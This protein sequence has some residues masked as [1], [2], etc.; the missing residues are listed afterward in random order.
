VGKPR[1]PIEAD[2]E[3]WLRALFPDAF[4]LPLASFHHEFWAWVWALEKGVKPPPFVA[5]WPR[6]FG[7]STNAEAAVA[8]VALMGKRSYGLY[9]SGTQD[10]A[11]DHVQNVARMLERPEVE[12]YYG[13]AAR[14]AVTKYGQREGWR[15]NRLRT[16]G[17]FT[18]DAAGLQSGL[19]GAK[20]DDARPDFIILDD[21]DSKHDSPATVAK[22]IAVLTTSIIPAGSPDVAILAVQNLIHDN[23]IFSRLAG[24]AAEEADFLTG[25]TVSGP[26]PAVEGL[27]YER[28]YTEDGR[29]RYRITAG[30]PVW[31]E[32]RDL[33]T[34]EAM[35]NDMGATAFEDECQHA[36]DH[37]KGGMFS[38]VE[39]QRVP[40]DQVP[41]LERVVVWCDPAVT[42]S[43][44]SNMNGIQV[45]GKAGDR[46]YRLWS[47]E[48][49]ATPEETLQTAIQQALKW[50][51]THVGVETDQGGDV[52]RPAFREAIRK[53]K[54]ELRERARAEDYD[55]WVAAGNDPDQWA[56]IEGRDWTMPPMP[57]FRSAKAGAG[58]GSKAHRWSLM[59]QAYETGA[60]FHVVNDEYTHV[61]LE[62]ALNRVPV[63]EPF[64]LADAAYWSWHDLSGRGSGRMVAY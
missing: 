25:R 10:Q 43:D 60:I 37:V 31:P 41:P 18:L 38:R 33:A 54:D 13:E 50:G 11:D 59:L 15:R 55:A 57:Q 63:A 58:V 45:D 12:A 4:S 61:T 47:W 51:A 39:F 24:V 1:P 32:G 64:D 49:R 3:T 8:A 52:W 53:I 27:T 20:L 46:I 62:K 35:M 22:K 34:C 23:S 7:K 30:R 36:V 26:H 28:Y 42:S 5:I 48:K 44:G 56:W 2:Y 14:P 40:L 6:G 19:R 16:A 17:G 9:I 21:I 29:P